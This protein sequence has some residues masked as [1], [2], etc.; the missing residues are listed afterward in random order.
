MTP[1]IRE[2]DGHELVPRLRHPKLPRRS[3]IINRGVSYYPAWYNK[4]LTR[5]CVWLNL[6]E[7]VANSA[8]KLRTFNLLFAA[9]IPHVSYTS[10]HSVAEEWTEYGPVYCRTLTR[11]AGG[12]GIVL[13]FNKEELVRCS[14]YTKWFA[15]VIEYRVHVWRNRVIKVSSKK[16]MGAEKRQENRIEEV[17]TYIRNHRN[18]WVFTKESELSEHGCEVAIGALACVGLDYGAVDLLEDA[19]G[20]CVVCEINSAP[21]MD[22]ESTIAAY[23]EAISNEL[24]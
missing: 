20:N 16:R 8:D 1:L 13:A 23:K 10:A 11:S 24:P 5:H 19:E 6:P 21:G 12:A 9:G 2:M 17:N 3:L 7:A 15:T 18:G 22:A 14:L 4:A